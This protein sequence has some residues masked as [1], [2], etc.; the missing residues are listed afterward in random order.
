MIYILHEVQKFFTRSAVSASEISHPNSYFLILT[1]YFP[2]PVFNFQFYFFRFPFYFQ[3][4]SGQKIDVFGLGQCAWDYIGEIENYP[5]SNT[6]CEMSAM[7]TQGGGPVA[8]ALVALT[9]W[10]YSCSFCGLVGGDT[11]GSQIIKS[12]RD[13][14]I[15]TSPIIVRPDFDSQFAFIAAEKNSGNRTIFWR[16]PTGPP[17]SAKELDYAM[18]RRSRVFH[19]DGLF[20]EASIA[21]ARYA[22]E[23]GITVVVDAGTLREGMLELAKYSNYFIVSESF[24][25]DLVQNDNPHLACEKLQRLGPEVVGVTLGGKGYLARSRHQW[26]ER[27]AYPVNAIDTTGCGDLFHAGI[28]NGILRGWN[29]EKTLDFSAWAAALVS[30]QLGGRAGIP[31][32]DECIARF[33]K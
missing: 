15:D 2:L 16:R 1:S 27:E 9:R 6:K 33:E 26:I 4:M 3:F 11:F 28:T 20:S 22:Q 23:A 30:T 19:T 32:F 24:A 10:G 14:N 29:L 17:I 31:S 13:E 7:V 12:L 18:I 8:T 21:G 25:R 5:S